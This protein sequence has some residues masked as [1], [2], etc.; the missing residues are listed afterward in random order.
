MRNQI[1][2]IVAIICF[3]C[4][5]CGGS[6]EQASGWPTGSLSIVMSNCSFAEAGETL[7]ISEE[8][9]LSIV[10]QSL[11][12]SGSDLSS[13]VKGSGGS[14]GFAEGDEG[15][16]ESE[17]IEEGEAFD[18]LEGYDE[19]TD[20]PI[21]PPVSMSITIDDELI[22]CDVYYDEDTIAAA[23]GEADDKCYLQAEK[24]GDTDVPELDSG[25]GDGGDDP[26]MPID[27]DA[28]WLNSH[29]GTYCWDSGSGGVAFEAFQID[30]DERL[31]I[32]NP[33]IPFGTD[34]MEFVE[35]VGFSDLLPNII[36]FELEW[37]LDPSGHIDITLYFDG[38]SDAIYD[39]AGVQAS[40]KRV[41]DELV[42]SC[43]PTA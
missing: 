3:A 15:F 37:A 27:G 30:S 36:S 12:L 6:G 43:T 40:F 38:E 14:S 7:N 32:A 31:Y 33:N 19:S 34:E 25:A 42:I 28:G 21:A 2:G 17:A 22:D 20:G 11:E 16:E 29:E 23:C 39:S 26:V 24:S 18:N 41:S 13:L 9:E 35:I 4:G 5:A 1:I 10:P 8:G